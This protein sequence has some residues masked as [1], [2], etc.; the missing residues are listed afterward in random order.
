V[1]GF[2]AEEFPGYDHTAGDLKC[3]AEIPAGSAYSGVGNST[4]EAEHD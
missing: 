2:E 4:A 1:P 3:G